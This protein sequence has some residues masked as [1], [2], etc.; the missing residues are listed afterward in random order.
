M[1]TTRSSLIRAE[2]LETALKRLDKGSGVTLSTHCLALLSFRAELILINKINT[3]VPLQR[4]YL[5][6]RYTLTKGDQA[7]D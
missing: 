3:L 7:T 4:G 1:F 2:F 6:V 5:G